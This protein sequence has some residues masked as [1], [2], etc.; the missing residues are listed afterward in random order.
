M[1]NPTALTTTNPRPIHCLSIFG[2]ALAKPGFGVGVGVSSGFGVAGILVEVG[3]LVG[4]ITV[5][6]RVGVI[7]TVGANLISSF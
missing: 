7:V 5:G 2:K 1:K 3:V 4:A 6:V